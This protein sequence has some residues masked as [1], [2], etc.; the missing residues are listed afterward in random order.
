MSCATSSKQKPRARKHRPWD[1]VLAR[2]LLSPCLRLLSSWHALDQTFRPR[3]ENRTLRQNNLKAADNTARHE[4]QCG[5]D[6]GHT[7][8]WGIS[9]LSLP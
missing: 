3:A 7:Y 9:E 6:E 2:S 4:L 1:P 5:K 8:C